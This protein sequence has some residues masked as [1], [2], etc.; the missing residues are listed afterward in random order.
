MATP[1]V[2]AARVG[3]SADRWG[4]VV[5]RRFS[6]DV[7]LPERGA[8]RV[9]DSSSAWLVARH[10]A[11][12]SE[13]LVRTWTASRLARPSDCEQQVRLWRPDLPVPGADTQVDR[14]VLDVPSGYRTDLVVAVQPRK[15]GIEGVA[16]AFGAAVGRCYA[17]VYTTSAVG[18][19]A[20]S[21]VGR[22]LAIV[23]DGIVRRV[24]VLTIEDRIRP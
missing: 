6:L 2:P 17:L 23:V 11:S 22:R 14:Q 19:G 20:E 7:P 13:L 24:R 12:A 15:P 3:I 9:D 21:A 5:S 16:L 1:L 18:P 4:D 8:W 10:A